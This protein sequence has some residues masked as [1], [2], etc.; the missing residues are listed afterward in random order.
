MGLAAVAPYVEHQRMYWAQI[1]KDF[2]AGR[3]DR[4][5]YDAANAK[6]QEAQ[7]RKLLKKIAKDG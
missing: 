5:G 1:V 2:E 6:A 7:L 4:T 3:P